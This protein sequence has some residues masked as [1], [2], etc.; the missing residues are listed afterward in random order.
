[1]VM[2]GLK[3]NSCMEL[4]HSYAPLDDHGAQI[5]LPKHRVS[6][7]ATHHDACT[8]CSLREIFLSQ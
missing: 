8:T 7:P 3:D 1:M 2:W 5:R 6:V 4:G